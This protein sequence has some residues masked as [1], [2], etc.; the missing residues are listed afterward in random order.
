MS[1]WWSEW[2]DVYFN[3]MTLS[4]P[5]P[6]DLPAGAPCVFSSSSEGL[7]FY[8][9]DLKG[10]FDEAEEQLWAIRRGLSDRPIPL[11]PTNKLK[12]DAL[13]KRTRG[14]LFRPPGPR[15][16]REAL[17]NRLPRFQKKNIFFEPVEKH[18]LARC[19]YSELGMMERFEY[20]MSQLA[21]VDDM[22]VQLYLD[23]LGHGI[24]AE[25]KKRA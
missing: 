13:K 25:M 10:N 24:N 19:V 3:L 7:S 9:S 2:R 18:E 6:W 21:H 23:V 8:E 17:K 20:P 11:P 12:P 14:P 1:T 16:S 22:C 5:A 15:A 4:T